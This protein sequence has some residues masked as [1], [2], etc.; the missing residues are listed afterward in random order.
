MI[1][2]LSQIYEGKEEMLF[3]FTA[4]N[5]QLW[6]NGEYKQCYVPLTCTQFFLIVYFFLV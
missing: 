4:K 5:W 6:K 2:I 1:L 3:G